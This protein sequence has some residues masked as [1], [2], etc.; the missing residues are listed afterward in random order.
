MGA[1]WGIFVG[2]L[3]GVAAKAVSLTEGEP[4]H[5]ITTESSDVLVIVRAGD[6]IGTAHEAMERRH[7]RDFLIDVPAVR[8]IQPHPGA[9]V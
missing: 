2:G 4:R 3:S 8:H 1:F 9:T 7:P 5:T 6:R